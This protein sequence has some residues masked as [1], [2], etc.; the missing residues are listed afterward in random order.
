VWSKKRGGVNRIPALFAKSVR[1]A[2]FFSSI[3][4]DPS[5]SIPNQLNPLLGHAKKHVQFPFNCG[6]HCFVFAHHLSSPSSLSFPSNNFFAFWRLPPY[7]TIFFSARGGSCFTPY[8]TISR[9]LLLLH[10]RMLFCKNSNCKFFPSRQMVVSRPLSV[11]LV[12]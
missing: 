3:N 4:N 7:D 12:N 10:T 8:Y 2:L 5:K 6:G 9:L 11:L 1:D